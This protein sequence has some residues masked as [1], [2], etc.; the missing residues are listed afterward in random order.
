MCFKISHKID[1]NS[2]YRFEEA[3]KIPLAA[4]NAGV[5]ENDSTKIEA[6]YRLF[7]ENAAYVLEVRLPWV[8]R[9][10][11]SSW[12][13]SNNNRLYIQSSHKHFTGSLR[14]SD[15]AHEIEHEFR[16]RFVSGP[17][18]EN[19][20]TDDFSRN[21]V[22]ALDAVKRR[23]LFWLP[24]APFRFREKLP[25]IIQQ[26]QTAEGAPKG[27]TEFLSE[28]K[29]IA[30]QTKIR[31]ELPPKTEFPHDKMLYDAEEQQLAFV[32]VN[33]K[34]EIKCRDPDNKKIVDDYA[35]S[36]R[37]IPKDEYEP[38]ISTVNAWIWMFFFQNFRGIDDCRR[39]QVI[40]WF[41]S[42]FSPRNGVAK[43][44]ELFRI[45]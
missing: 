10:C 1:I 39:V 23:P 16:S 25:E 42:W 38:A 43:F 20:E 32:L 3:I 24:N 22:I 9:T 17:W 34:S 4:I 14:F 33:L 18:N 6:N 28:V 45:L 26:T 36:L 19:D 5:E 13:S 7:F 8:S 30:Y 11:L 31:K 21:L 41:S 15:K 35:E 29:R 40:W 27:L 2:D 44:A 12:A 37:A